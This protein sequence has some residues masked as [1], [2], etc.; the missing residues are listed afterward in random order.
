MINWNVLGHYIVG[1]FIGLIMG[2]MGCAILASGQ[3]TDMRRLLYEYRALAM[4]NGADTHAIDKELWGA[5]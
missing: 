4:K 3:Y 1:G 5:H 2:Y